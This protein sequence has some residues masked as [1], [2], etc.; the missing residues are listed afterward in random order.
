MSS[1]VNPAVARYLNDVDAW[2]ASQPLPAQEKIEGHMVDRSTLHSRLMDLLYVPTLEELPGWVHD[3]LP[4]DVR[5]RLVAKARGAAL[6]VIFVDEGE[7]ADW[8]RRVSG[9][10]VKG[11]RDVTSKVQQPK[12]RQG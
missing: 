10:G 3:L 4:D 9:Q 11:R 5:V 7:N 2:L 12:E 8:L 6:P 1:V